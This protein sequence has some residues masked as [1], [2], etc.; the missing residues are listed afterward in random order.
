M[1]LPHPEP[2][3]ACH[4]VVIP[5]RHVAAFYDLD[6]QEQ[7]V[8]WELVTEIRKRIS[9]GLIVKGFEVGFVDGPRNGEN[10]AHVQVIPRTDGDGVVLPD[11]VEWV[12]D[13]L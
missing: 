12:R 2:V 10:H 4:M 6:V 3:T 5:R 8:V 11:G 1:A 13:E 9:T 7:R